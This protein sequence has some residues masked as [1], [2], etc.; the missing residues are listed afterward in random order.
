MEE[1]KNTENVEEVKVDSV[2][3]DGVEENLIQLPKQT[4]Q[5]NPLQCPKQNMTKLFN[6]PRIR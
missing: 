3:G 1:N 6:L 4:K 5:Q 2:S